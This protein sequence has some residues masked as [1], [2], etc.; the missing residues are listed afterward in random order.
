[1]NVFKRFIIGITLLSWGCDSLQKKDTDSLLL[2]YDRPAEEWTEALPVGN[3]RLGAMIFGGVGED[4]IQF[5]EETLWTGAPRDYHREGA[6]Q[7]LPEIRR[8]LFEGKQEAA[9]ELAERQ[10]MGKLYHEDDYDSLKKAWLEG[11][12]S[13]KGVEGDPAKPT[14]PDSDWKEMPVPSDDGWRSVGLEGLNGAVWFR[15]SFDLPPGWERKDL[16]LELG[17][18]RD[19]DFT[20]VNGEQAG[21]SNGKD[22]NRKYRIP[23]SYLQHGK[24]ILAVQVI[25]Y[26]DKGG[27]TGFDDSDEPMV[28]YPE[29]EKENAISLNGA[30]K[31]KIQNAEPPEFPDYMARYQPFGDLK[32]RFQGHE[33][34]SNYRRELNISRAVARTSYEVNGVRYTREYFASAPN[35]VMAVHLSASQPGKISFTAALSSPHTQSFTRKMDD[36]TLGLSLKIRDG[37]LNG[38]GYLRV[39]AHA[40]EVSVSDEQIRIEAADEVTLYLTAGTDFIDYK[41][42]SGDADRVC[43]EAMQSLEGLEYETVK[44]AHI[45]EYQQYFN[46]FSIDL[47]NSTG[48][49]LPTDRRIRAYA[50]GDQSSDQALPALYLQYG[51]YLL[52]SSSRPGTQPANL[53]G[54]WNDLMLPPWDSKYT[55]NINVEM[56]YWPAELLNLSACHEPLFQMTEE[57]AENGKRTAKAHYNCRGWVLHHNTDLW[58]GTA[59]VNA[60]NHGI[61]VGGSAWL[62][63]HLWEHYLFTQDTAFLKDR[64]YPVMKEAARFYTDFLVEEPETGWLISSPSNSPELGGLVAGPTMDHQ[65]IRDLFG[66]CIRAADILDIDQEFRELLAE[67]RAKIAPNQIGR[68]GQLQEWLEDTDDPEEH[69]RHVSHLWGVHPGRDI[70]WETSPELMEAAR[71][72]LEFRGDGGT[73]WSL[74][75][76]VNFWARFKDGNHARYMLDQLLRPAVDSSGRERGGSYPNLLDAHPPFQIDGNFGGAAGIAEMLVQSHQGFIELLPALPEAWPKGNIRGVCA[77]GGFI[78]N[79][80]WE[81]G[82]LQEVEVTS[83]AGGPCKLRYKELSAEI[84]TE[85]DQTYRLNGLLETVISH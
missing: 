59:P 39:Q 24:N 41:N 35:Q 74:A 36:Q 30:W 18:I 48:D 76:K 7:Y 62:C 50:R 78:L 31:Y 37:A 85:K 40:G 55:S 53:Q 25:S 43:R 19:Q 49:S 2:W 23:G 81:E 77:R 5:N 70:T 9:E 47:G 61:W 34:A 44:S 21:T 12:F 10:F 75:W 13:L 14:Y 84:N 32:L 63:H 83:R 29:G 16:I 71:Q 22:L 38:A 56:N 45:R 3:G 28:I 46:T 57:L 4:R 60:A 64:A 69:H 58:R 8:L 15:K 51:R 27:F 6:A 11:V 33:R 65:L 73:G 1:M 67:K 54:I 72:S 79:I 52:I 26:F 20:Y 68:H 82:R 66:N 80:R 42:V 17:R